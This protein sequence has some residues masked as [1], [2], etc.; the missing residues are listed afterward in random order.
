MRVM[1]ILL[2]IIRRL[3]SRWEGL[4][5]FLLNF[6]R[7]AQLPSRDRHRFNALSLLSRSFS[8]GGGGEGGSP[9]EA[10]YVNT[11]S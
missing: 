5:W 6:Y 3:Q 4:Q 7:I 11:Q 2:L 1:Q 8:G 9:K 10:N